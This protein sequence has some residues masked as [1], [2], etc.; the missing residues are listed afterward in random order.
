MDENDRPTASGVD[1]EDAVRELDDRIPL[2][3]AH[4]IGRDAGRA[5]ESNAMP[6]TDVDQREQVFA[7][8]GVVAPPY[9][10]ETLAI[11]FENSNSL[12]QNVDS[13]LTNIDA[14]GHRLEPI[15]DLD[16]ED[17]DQRIA[18]AIYVERLYRKDGSAATGG[19]DA[20]SQPA[21]PTPEE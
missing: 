3:K 1:I 7:G 17:V 16:A 10:P 9:E 21:E 6:W 20:P 8:M 18:Q 15:I 19:A 11:L 14:F 2:I 4:L 5:A 12:R 13:Y